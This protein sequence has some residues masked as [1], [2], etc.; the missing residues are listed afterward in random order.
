MRI[1]DQNGTEITSPDLE[2]GHLQEERMLI[3]H[4][5]AVEAAAEQGHWETVAQYANGGKDVEWIVDVPAVA[6][7]DSWD[8]Y[9]NILRYVPYTLAQRNAMR[10]EQLKASLQDT[11]YMILKVVEGAATMSEIAETVRQRAAWR[12]EINELETQ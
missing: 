8:E 11:D 1:M 10:I 12:A 2:Q 6:G 5:A 4:H 9:E 7:K 3:A